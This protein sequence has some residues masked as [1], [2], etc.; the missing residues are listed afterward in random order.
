MTDLASL[1]P[2]VADAAELLVESLEGLEMI[3]LLAGEPERAWS[4]DEM[5]ERLRV[6][7]G[8]ARRELDRAHARRLTALVS[9]SP[10]RHQF[11]PADQASADAAALLVEFH[12]TR[13]IDLINHVAARTLDRL[14]STAGTRRG[15]GS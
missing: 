2:L 6:S 15:N 4:A 9:D 12:A 5:A 14:R 10:T 7:I 3:I 8:T 13:R 11:A 1:P